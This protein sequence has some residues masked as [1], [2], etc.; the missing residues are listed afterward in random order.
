VLGLGSVGLVSWVVL[1]M[2]G[3][4]TIL[5][6]P[7]LAAYFGT[8]LSSRAQTGVN[9]GV[10]LVAFLVQYMVGAVI[11][12]FEPPSSGGYEPLAYQVSFAIVVLL[13]IA[14]FAWFLTGLR[15]FRAVP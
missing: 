13:Q 7:W 10:F 11:D 8:G 2:T 3:Q 15:K 9:F 6:Y 1:A 14:A 5:S 12:L 4:S